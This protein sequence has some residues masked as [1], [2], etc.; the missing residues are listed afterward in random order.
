MAQAKLES[1]L[2]FAACLEDS[3]CGF[4]IERVIRKLPNGDEVEYS[5]HVEQRATG[6]HHILRAVN[7]GPAKCQKLDQMNNYS[8]NG[9]PTQFHA[10]PP[11]ERAY[12]EN[13]NQLPWSLEWPDDHPLARGQK[14][15]PV[16]TGPFGK[17]MR[18]KGSSRATRTAT[19]AKKETSAVDGFLRG[20]EEDKRRAELYGEFQNTTNLNASSQQ[21]GIAT[22]TSKEPVQVM[23]YGF[24]P[25]TQW[26]AISHYERASGGM[27]CEDYERHPPA[28]ARRIPTMFSSPGLGPRRALT[29]AEKKLSRS[30]KGGKA[31]IRVT[32]DSA[33][34]A[35]R[36][37]YFSPHVIQGHWVYAELYADGI[38]PNNDEPIPLRQED[39]Q[40][41]LTISAKPSHI[42]THKTTQS[43]GPAFTRNIQA[44]QASSNP[45]LPRSFISNTAN[46]TS[47][48]QR[49]EPESGSPST[50]SSA[51]ATAP[52]PGADNATLR[53]RGSEN[54][55]GSQPQN[56]ALASPLAHQE[57]TQYMRFFPD[58]P[59]TVLRP[60]S[61]AFLPQP[62]W[63]QKTVKY[64]EDMGLIP[65]DVIGNAVP[66][67][68]SGVFDWANA[69]FYWKIC[70]WIDSTFGTDLCGLK[71]D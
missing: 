35:E 37:C 38:V 29:A 39:R 6:P 55:G 56:T 43:L 57:T 11:E 22:T 41:D 3:C 14:R 49:P 5:Y 48:S 30:Y 42:P 47:N 15:R 17:S 8:A 63:T 71:D 21:D 68:E 36:A 62:T 13:G 65:G 16:E 32:F 10:V 18:R 4:T 31:W 7:H 52:T 40:S 45:T 53:Q 51:T 1:P 28:E 69:S 61:E 20:L 34:A 54:Q 70:F 26:A 27:I 44:Q 67:T 50:A 2:F 64:F 19:P 25:S 46:Q 12:D 66:L 33:E 59:R 24:S 60:A 58:L 23:L 9:R